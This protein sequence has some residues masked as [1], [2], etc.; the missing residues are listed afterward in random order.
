MKISN[1]EFENNVFL[2]P[3]AGVTDLPFRVI[4]K[5]MGC[6]L[7]YS[8]MVSAR[9]LCYKS[10]NTI[11]MLTIDKSEAPIAIQIFG[12]DP[13]SMAKACEFFNDRDDIC[14]IDIN[15]GCPVPKIVRNGEGSALMKSPDLAAEIVKE[16]KKATKKPVTVKFRKGFD[17]AHIT[18]VDFAKTMEQAGVDAVAIHGRTRAQMY[19]GKADWNI[20]KQVKSAVKIPVIGNG[21]VFSVEDAIKIVEVTNCDAIMVAR[22][23]Q[24][25]PWLFKQIQ[26]ALK[27]EKVDYPS[28]QEKIDLTIIHYRE[29]LEYFGEYKAVREM[30]KHIG[31]YIKG[32]KNSTEIKNNLNYIN[33]SEKVIELLME[34]KNQL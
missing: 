8:E 3:M 6:G 17:E 19:D 2:A 9:A 13:K 29:A 10:E 12:N 28:P 20:I 30:R 31:W 1:L 26:Q 16:V 21:D 14:I 11:A 23:S 7:V 32:L 4:C 27:G 18:A 25:N 34:Y 24:G 33:E 5:E 22:G 15:M